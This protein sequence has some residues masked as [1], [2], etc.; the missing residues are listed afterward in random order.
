MPILVGTKIGLSRSSSTTTTTTPMPTS[1]NTKFPPVTTTKRT[2]VTGNEYWRIPHISDVDDLV[3]ITVIDASHKLR[4]QYTCKRQILLHSMRYFKTI[5]EKEENKH[6]D[7]SIHCDV[8]IFEWLL[9]YIHLDYSKEPSKEH[10]LKEYKFELNNVMSILIS[11]D[12]L[13]IETLVDLCIEYILQH[14][15]QVLLQSI[16]ISCLSNS[17]LNKWV[18]HCTPMLL[19]TIKVK[20]SNKLIHTIYKHRLIYDFQTAT[21]EFCVCSCCGLLFQ[22]KFYKQLYCHDI[23]ALVDIDSSKQITYR[24][25]PIAHWSFTY[26]IKYLRSMNLQWDDIYWICWA[27]TIHF[28]TSSITADTSTSVVLNA[29]QTQNYVLHKDGIFIHRR[30]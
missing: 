5:L 13:Q 29:S 2:E 23:H 19:S 24:H 28:S 8:S 20:K 12:F 11:S 17:L 3:Q 7:L 27:S 14:L 26:Y 18:M 22:K 21:H 4:R 25:T 16:D 6:V 10:S 30:Y 15:E 1:S 9:E